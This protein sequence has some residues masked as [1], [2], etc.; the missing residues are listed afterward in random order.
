MSHVMPQRF[1][2]RHLNLDPK[3]T[4]HMEIAARQSHSTATLD[5]TRQ[6]SRQ[7]K[8]RYVFVQFSRIQRRG[9]AE[10]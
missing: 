4:Y 9:G 6:A 8:P 2:R 5:K 7:F 10:A 3:E 1:F